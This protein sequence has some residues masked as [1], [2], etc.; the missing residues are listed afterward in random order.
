MQL[1]FCAAYVNAFLHILIRGSNHLKLS[2]L[3]WDNGQSCT[4][5]VKAT[6]Q[7]DCE[8]Y[9]VKEG[10]SEDDIDRPGTDHRV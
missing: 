9:E 1:G 10:L 5:Q 6:N 4:S 8:K 7:C 2:Q 3:N